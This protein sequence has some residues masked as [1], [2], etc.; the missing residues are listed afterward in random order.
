VNILKYQGF[1][2]IA[3]QKKLSTIYS[4][5]EIATLKFF[6]KDTTIPNGGC[7]QSLIKISKQY[8]YC[9]IEIELLGSLVRLRRK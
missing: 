2:I 3:P 8:L 1:Y 9:A 5:K 6:R 7:G 4:I